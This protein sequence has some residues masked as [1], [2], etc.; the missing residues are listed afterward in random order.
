[1]DLLC[2]KPG[3]LTSLEDEGYIQ[4]SGGGCL[5]LTDAGKMVCDSVAQGLVG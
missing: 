3:L 1:M 4:W 5:C 2:D